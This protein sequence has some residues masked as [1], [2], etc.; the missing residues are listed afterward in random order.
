M[1]DRALQADE[2]EALP[3]AA[4]ARLWG[5]C[6]ATVR[7]RLRSGD[8]ASFRVGR[9]RRVLRADLVAF[10]AARKAG[11][12]CGSRF[13]SLPAPEPEP[14]SADADCLAGDDEIPF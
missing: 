6:E 13:E 14:L 10:V 5:V 7:A 3:I 2:L 8:I 4:V 9:A 12:W 1:K 11:G